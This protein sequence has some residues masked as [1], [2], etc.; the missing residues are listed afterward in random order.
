MKITPAYNSKDETSL[1]IIKAHRSSLKPRLTYRT[2]KMGHSHRRSPSVAAAIVPTEFLP[3][4]PR[5]VSVDSSTDPEDDFHADFTSKLML[6][7]TSSSSESGYAS[8]QTSVLSWRPCKLEWDDEIL[9]VASLSEEPPCT[10]PAD[11]AMHKNDI[12]D[13]DDWC[14][15]PKSSYHA[16]TLLSPPV[17]RI[18][19]SNVVF[20]HLDPTV[21]SEL[22]LPDSF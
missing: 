9:S 10:P 7:P 3:I 19:P 4:K 5:S 12:V 2:T 15:T 6:L 13:D 8:P 21:A 17:N 20:L 22:Y 11:A 16:R 1:E 18:S 14:C